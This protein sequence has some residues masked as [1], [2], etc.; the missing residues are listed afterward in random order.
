MTN[1]EAR[2]WLEHHFDPL[3]DG[4]KQSEA[5]SLAIKALETIPKYKDAYGKGWI[6]GAKASYE[7]LKMCEEEQGGDLISRDELLKAIDTWDKFGV[8]D[9]NSL[10][11]LDNLSLPYYVPYIHYDDVIKCIKGMP[12]VNP[13]PCEDAIS[14][15]KVLDVINLNWEY[16][17]NCIR[18]IEKLPPVKQEP[19]WIPV[20]EMLPEHYQNILFS[21]KTDRVFEGRYFKDETEH[22]WYSFRDECFAW[23]NVVTAWMPLPKPYEPQERSEKG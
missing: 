10:F 16:R 11:R 15:Q 6:D 13:Q 7:H 20:S 18:A 21:T 19:R 5:V 17:R 12:S 14:R 8:D 3:P 9:T 1:E 4:T 2:A 23:N 22:Q